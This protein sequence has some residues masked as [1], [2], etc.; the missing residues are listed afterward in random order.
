MVPA[1]PGDGNLQA[2]TAKLDLLVREFA[3]LKKSLTSQDSE[4]NKRLI[5]LQ[6]QVDS[7]AAIIRS[8]QQFLEAQDRNERE[9]NVVVSGIPAGQES[10]NGA[11]KDDE[12][13]NKVSKV[14]GLPRNEMSLHRLGKEDASKKKKTQ[15]TSNSNY[16][17][18][19]IVS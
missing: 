10:L 19:K 17:P 1:T 18:I 8:Q 7:Q 16:I 3:D 2:V 14:I 4:T 9:C 15:E 11:T 13:V 5:D 12:K 6:S